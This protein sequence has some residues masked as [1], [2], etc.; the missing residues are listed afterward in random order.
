[1][2]C[3]HVHFQRTTHGWK[4]AKC[5]K[6]FAVSVMK[7]FQQGCVWNA[8]AEIWFMKSVETVTAKT[9][10]TLSAACTT[11]ELMNELLWKLGQQRS[12]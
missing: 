10:I 4:L 8:H 9:A 6:D 7:A 12:S 11:S 2:V 1:M 3:S 5:Q